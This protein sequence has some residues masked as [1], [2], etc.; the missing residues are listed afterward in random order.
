MRRA[1]VGDVVQHFAELGELGRQ[2]DFLR[3]LKADLAVDFAEVFAQFAEHTGY[4]GVCVQQVGR[5]VALKAEHQ[6]EVEAVVAG[7]VLG[8]VG[9]FDCAHPYGVG[10]LAQFGF[11]QFRVL[12]LDQ[13]VGALFGFIDQVDQFHRAAVAGLE[14]AAVGTVHGA[15]THV[16]QLHAGWDEAGQARSAE[17][18]LE[19]QG[20]ALVDEVQ[21]AIG[22]QYVGAITGGSQV[23]GGIQVAAA[24][25]LHDQWQWVAFGVLELVHEHALGAV[26]L[27]EQALGLEVS[28][29]VGQVVVVGALA[30]DVGHA[31][32]HAQAVVECLAVAQGDI[33]EAGPQAQA[34]GIAGLQLHHQFA[35]ALG[36]LGRLVEAL[37][38]GAVEVFQVGQ[39]TVGGGWVFLHIGQ[40][41]AELGAPVANVVLADHLVAEEFEHAGDAVADDG[42][43]Q[44]AN[45]HLFGQVGRGQIDHH[46]LCRADLA[47][48]QGGI[49]QGDFQ[50]LS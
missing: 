6:F 50:A 4:A 40:Q 46:A 38:R 48:I 39:F 41:H 44:M 28:N 2:V 5:G 34:F 36:E 21:G 19:V 42:R 30:L 27:A 18:H 49:G 12:A 10:D 35:S 3:R 8:Q 24:G 17:D 32:F 20:L 7:A 9:V 29:H 25:F 16:L 37:L 1:F 33:V 14:W 15:E 13:T 31:Q 26:A 45:V 43:A 23:S 47:H 22:L 11:V